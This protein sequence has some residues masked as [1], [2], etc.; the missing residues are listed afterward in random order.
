MDELPRKYRSEK[1][2]RGQVHCWFFF[3]FR[4]SDNAI[5]VNYGGEFREWQWMPF[6]K[7]LR[8]VVD[9]RRPV[10]RHLYEWFQENIL[11]SNVT[12]VQS[13]VPHLRGGTEVRE[14]ADPQDEDGRP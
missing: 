4:G 5:N 10:Y 6:D 9:F 13:S 14:G 11:A 2:G 1:T 8:S 3:E 12:E 7:L